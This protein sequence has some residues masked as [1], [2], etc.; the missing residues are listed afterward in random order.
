M[1]IKALTRSLWRDP[2]GPLLLAAQVA[3]SMMIFANVA[4]VVFVRLDTTS[5]ST[6]MDLE[7]IFWISSQGYAADYDQQSTVKF[8]LEYLNSLPGVVAACATD[9][10]PQTFVGFRTSLS[11]APELKGVK[12][13]VLLYQMT[14]KFV[15]ALGLHL[16]RGR[17]PAAD[18]VTP[19]RSSAGPAANL[20][21]PEVVITEVLADRLFGGAEHAIG[22]PLYFSVNN[23]RS[24]TVVGVVERMQ[25]SPL[26]VSG[27]DFVNHVVFAPAVAAGPHALYLI[28]TQPGRLD[29]VMARVWQE[30]RPLQRGRTVNAMETLRNTAW[31]ARASDRN[32][33]IVL[34]VL[35]S[36]VLAVTMLGLFG[37][38]SF[39]V[40]SRTKEIGTRR[41]IG[42]T[43][44]D[45]LRHF[46]F[47]NWLITTAGIVAGWGVTLAFAL[48][49]NMLLEL[50]RMPMIFLVAAMGLIW[51][52]GLLAAL[53]PALW[54]S[55][56]APAVATRAA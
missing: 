45:I 12:S 16:V 38:A 21:G 7:N 1:N 14:E 32:E 56:V 42:A 33:A 39:T 37:F 46:L 30:L 34:A 6:G 28:R 36:F 2:L 11:T 50:P 4:Y 20:F 47:E 44:G 10:L 52:A 22:K 17:A 55:R 49:L 29:E 3:L 48:Q 27:G 18:A 13:A 43:R 26:F 24:A 15:D 51:A 9:S 31:Q 41:A 8:D 5:R 40:A 23:G 25:G 54:G 35:S 53:M 19:A